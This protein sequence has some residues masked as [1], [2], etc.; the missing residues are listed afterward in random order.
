MNAADSGSSTGPGAG[1]PGQDDPAALV[2]DIN[3]TRAELGDTVEALVAKAD[4]KAQAKQ[5]VAEAST[6]AK[7]KLQTMKQ[8]LAGQASQLTG[9]AGTGRGPAGRRGQR[10]DGARRR[11]GRRPDGAARRAPGRPY[12]RPH[13]VP[14]AAATAVGAVVLVGWLAVRAGGA[15]RPGAGGANRPPGLTGGTPV[16]RHRGG[17]LPA[18]A[19]GVSAPPESQRPPAG[20]V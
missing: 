5:R 9:K 20:P 19:V 14:F 3:R 12:R 2:E 15:D 7:E 8:G 10:Q 11:C 18:G 16:R 17:A 13:R 4:V 1:P 6:Q